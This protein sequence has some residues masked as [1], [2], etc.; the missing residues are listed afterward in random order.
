LQTTIPTAEDNWHVGRFFTTQTTRIL[1]DASGNPL[2][3]VTARD[4]QKNTAGDDPVLTQL[5]ASQFDQF[6]LF[7]VDLGEGLVLLTARES[8]VSVKEAVASWPLAI[9]RI[10]VSL[11][12]RWVA[13]A[14][15]TSSTPNILSRQVATGARR[16]GQPGHL[17]AQL[18]FGLQ[19]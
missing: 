16:S 8:L 10:L 12:V 3:E 19:W 5:D 11:Y 14:R 13:L 1:K 6:W 2:V 18:P 15:H 7:A 4:R 17:V 9:I